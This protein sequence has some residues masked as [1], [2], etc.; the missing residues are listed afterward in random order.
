MVTR[1][2]A[3]HARHIQFSILLVFAPRS[4]LVPKWTLPKRI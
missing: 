4:L 3:S 2:D 1:A